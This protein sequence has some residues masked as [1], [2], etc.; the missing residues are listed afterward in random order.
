MKSP[1]PKERGKEGNGQPSCKESPACGSLRETET[2]IERERKRQKEREGE[3][4]RLRKIKREE[5]IRNKEKEVGRGDFR[6]CYSV[7]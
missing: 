1:P 5:V 7:S 3:R 4:H 2:E 6:Q